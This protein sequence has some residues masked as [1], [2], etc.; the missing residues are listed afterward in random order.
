MPICC[1]ILV[2][3]DNHKSTYTTPLVNSVR[4][5]MLLTNIAR[6][7]KRIIV[8][9]HLKRTPYTFPCF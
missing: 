3:T 1:M 4:L 6:K 9:F 5:D 8:F 7:L 2:N